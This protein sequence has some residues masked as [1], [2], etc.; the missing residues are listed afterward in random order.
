MECTDF[1]RELTNVSKFTLKST[2]IEEA[3]DGLK[4]P[5]GLRILENRSEPY[6]HSLTNSKCL[7]SLFRFDADAELRYDGW[8]CRSAAADIKDVPRF[9]AKQRDYRRKYETGTFAWI[10]C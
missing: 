6:Q 7:L 5:E 4:T 3:K 1:I 9:D 2:N 8:A 10:L